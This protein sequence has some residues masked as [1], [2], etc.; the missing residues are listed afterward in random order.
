MVSI[1]KERLNVLED[2]LYDPRPSIDTLQE[3]F[4]RRLEALIASVEA[5]EE[6]P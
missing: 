1:E 4:L 5:Q 3:N 6:C 2:V